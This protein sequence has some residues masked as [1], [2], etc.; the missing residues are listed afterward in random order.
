[1]E[2]GNNGVL[3][4]ATA[5][6]ER[7]AQLR[8]GEAERE[9][10]RQAHYAASDELHAAQGTL[11]EASLEVSRLE[12]RIRYVREGRERDEQRLT[13]RKGQTR[14]WSQRQTDA[15]DELEQ[16]AAQIAMADEQSEVL[17][18]QA[19]EQAGN[20]PVFEDA[21]RTA[22]SRSNEQRSAVATVQQ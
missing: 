18:A 16:V 21:L 9:T 7:M 20:L 2:S 13:E 14:Q 5:L 8:N 3:A 1:R 12:E 15:Q 17:T 22:Q 10:I 19:E 11:A 6:E 4:A